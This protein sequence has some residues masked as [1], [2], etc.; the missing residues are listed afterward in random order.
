MQDESKG[1]FA[2]IRFN[3]LTYA[4]GGVMAVVKGRV[5]SLATISQFE[6]GQSAED[7]QAG[8]RYFLEKTDLKPG[9]D[10]GQA[11]SLRQMHLDLRESEA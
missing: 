4:A 8:W 10:P 5:N 3:F 6:A 11:T 9:M 2:V 1:A 7:R